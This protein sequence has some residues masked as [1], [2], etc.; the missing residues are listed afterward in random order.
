MIVLKSNIEILSDILNSAISNIIIFIVIIVIIRDVVY[1]IGCG[2][3]LWACW[4]WCIF[5]FYF[6]IF[7]ELGRFLDDFT[8]LIYC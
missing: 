8:F 4:I 5:W 1:D 3:T 2:T 7:M 6:S